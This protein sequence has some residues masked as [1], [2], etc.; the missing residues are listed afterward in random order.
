V[1]H[2]HVISNLREVLQTGTRIDDWSALRL[3]DNL[4][5]VGVT[6]EIRDWVSIAQ[7]VF[8]VG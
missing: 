5:A 3:V 7:G 8:G 1:V 2:T 4:N 6:V